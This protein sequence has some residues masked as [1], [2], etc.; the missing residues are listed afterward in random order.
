MPAVKELHVNGSASGGLNGAYLLNA[1]TI[2]DD[3][4]IDQLYGET[5]MD[6]FLYTAAGSYKDKVNSLGQGEI[7]T[8][9]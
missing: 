2:H 6:W 8:P 4:A 1:A 9:L 5:E 3:A 7:A